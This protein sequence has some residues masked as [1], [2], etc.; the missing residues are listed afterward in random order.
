MAVP[1]K[2]VRKL[3]VGRPNPLFRLETIPPN[4]HFYGGMANYAPSR[5]GQRFLVNLVLKASKVSPLDVV[6]N[7]AAEPKKQ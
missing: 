5:D 3:E 1:I 2:L 6:L 4:V 7:W